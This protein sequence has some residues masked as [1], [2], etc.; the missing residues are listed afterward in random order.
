MIPGQT[1][2]LNKN[3]SSKNINVI[4][5]FQIRILQ[6]RPK[7]VLFDILYPMYL[8]VNLPYY[9][10]GT[11]KISVHQKPGNFEYKTHLMPFKV[12]SGH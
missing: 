10:A 4:G 5:N 8:S 3:C 2:L 12:G 1:S 9:V 11:L 6:D 7:Q